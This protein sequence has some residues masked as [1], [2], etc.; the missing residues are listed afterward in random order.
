[1]GGW[2]LQELLTGTRVGAWL[3]FQRETRVQLP[4]SGLVRI[5]V[6]V[7]LAQGLW[8]HAKERIWSKNELNKLITNKSEIESQSE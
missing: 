7:L 2:S 1:M 8:D 5:A 6:V 4:L 3:Q